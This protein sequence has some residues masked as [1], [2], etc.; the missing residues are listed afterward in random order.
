MQRPLQ[1][2]L[3]HQSDLMDCWTRSS[4][5]AWHRRLRLNQDQAHP[6][7]LVALRL[8]DSQRESHPFHTWDKKPQDRERC[9]LMAYAIATNAVWC[10]QTLSCLRMQQS[11]RVVHRYQ[12]GD[13]SKRGF[14]CARVQYQ[15]SVDSRVR[16]W[17][18]LARE[19][20]RPVAGHTGCQ[21]RG[22][23]L[24]LRA[25][26]PTVRTCRGDRMDM[27]VERIPLKTP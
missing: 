24:P 27:G 15:C 9:L 10:R 22:Q 7:H 2:H 14:L 8:R 13:G 20:P 4:K 21:L 18:Q 17:I 11:V 26:L 3:A 25:P 23:P 19:S 12:N 6:W 1:D 5:R 16:N